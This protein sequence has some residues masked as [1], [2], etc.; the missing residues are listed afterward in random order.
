MSTKI[1][2]DLCTSVSEGMRKTQH[3]DRV[4]L[5]HAACRPSPERVQAP[6]GLTP[7]WSL[8]TSPVIR[9]A[10]IK[11]AELLARCHSKLIIVAPHYT[12]VHLPPSYLLS[13]AWHV[14]VNECGRSSVDERMRDRKVR[15]R[16]T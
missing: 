8:R 9:E 3:P 5:P 12:V 4:K 16:F 2:L 7:S 14:N 13:R 10:I 6:S 15:K 1:T 11:Y